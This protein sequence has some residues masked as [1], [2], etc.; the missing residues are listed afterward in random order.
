MS[1]PRLT[2]YSMRLFVTALADV[3]SAFEKVPLDDR[4]ACWFFRHLKHR[5]EAETLRYDLA[6][7]H[8]LSLTMLWNR[9]DWLLILRDLQV[10]DGEWR[11]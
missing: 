10:R 2:Q 8:K 6:D 4:D 7:Q 1:E 11:W 3:L 9:L 5:I